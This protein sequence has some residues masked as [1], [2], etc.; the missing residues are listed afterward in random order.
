[1]SPHDHIYFRSFVVNS[2]KISQL[3]HLVKH[4]CARQTERIK[5][6]KNNSRGERK[7]KQKVN[8]I[9]LHV[10][11]IPRKKDRQIL[12]VLRPVN[13]AGSYE[14]EAKCI[15]TTS[16]ILIH[17]LK[18]SPLLKTWMKFGGKMKL[19]EL[20]RQKLGKY[21]SP[22]S[23]HSIQSYSL[24]YFRLRKR[25]PLIALDCHQGGPFSASAVPHC[26]TMRERTNN[27]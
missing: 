1:M 22:V 24:T 2:N 13:S 26:G 7:K 10:G 12:D 11:Y 23:R 3:I 6:R 20:G 4:K 18:H 17:Y 14:G 27:S 9:V 5:D 21:G 15:P 19:H 8:V 25:E 16:K